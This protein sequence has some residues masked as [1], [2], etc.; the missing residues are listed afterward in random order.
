[1]MGEILH[2]LAAENWQ[3]SRS[4]SEPAGFDIPTPRTGVRLFDDSS[5]RGIHPSGIRWIVGIDQLFGMAI[6]RSS[7]LGA[8]QFR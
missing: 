1:M 5:E 6:H 7:T 4:P 3:L 8:A 2:L